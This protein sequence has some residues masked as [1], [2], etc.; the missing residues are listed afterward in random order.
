MMMFKLIKIFIYKIKLCIV[1][2]QVKMEN[3]VELKILIIIN[4]KDSQNY[5]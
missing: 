3:K 4:L 1:R 5:L 2:I